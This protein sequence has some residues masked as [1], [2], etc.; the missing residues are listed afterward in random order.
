VEE[1]K[2][3]EMK[4]GRPPKLTQNVLDSIEQVINESILIC[5]DEELVIAINEL[6]PEEERFS[7]EAFSKWKRG[8]SQ[9]NNPLY[10]QFLRIIK[11]ALV[12]EK[13]RLLKLLESDK[14]QWQRYAWILERKFDEWNI[15]TKSEVDHTVNIPS[16][17]SITIKTN[18]D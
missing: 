2:R 16:L 14:T 9:Q 10:P 18:N 6:L 7:Y 1:E 5:T 4:E 11:K 13:S 15:K 17:P 3:K 8:L 12:A